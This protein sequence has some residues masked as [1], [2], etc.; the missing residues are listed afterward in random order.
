MNNKKLLFVCICM[1]G[2]VIFF[3]LVVHWL[4]QQAQG[5]V[6]VDALSIRAQEFITKNSSQGTGIW[7]EVRI[8][9]ASASADVISDVTITTPCFT[10][11]IPFAMVNQTEESVADRCTVRTKVLS[12]MG[13][14]VIASYQ[15]EDFDQDAGIVMRRKNP[16]TYQEHPLQVPNFAH[17]ALFVGTESITVF[18]GNT[19]KMITVAVSSLSQPD[20]FPIDQLTALLESIH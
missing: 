5:T 4:K 1:V 18:V 11:K 17:A 13:Q 8:K 10:V 19:G 15:S 12:P 16:E 7:S 2:S 3:L 9:N 14:L 20:Q 6:T